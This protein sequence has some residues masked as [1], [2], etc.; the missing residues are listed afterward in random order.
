M[1]IGYY[2]TPPEVVGS[3]RTFLSYPE[4][5]GSLLDPCTGEGAPSCYSFVGDTSLSPASPEERS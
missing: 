3:V 2:P 4:D 5:P 1:K